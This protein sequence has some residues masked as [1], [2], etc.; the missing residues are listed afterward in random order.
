MLE[1]GVG[2]EVESTRYRAAAGWGRAR[3]RGRGTQAGA[4]D[5]RGERGGFFPTRSLGFTGSVWPRHTPQKNE[6]PFQFLIYLADGVIR[7][8]ISALV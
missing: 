6:A 4:G 5:V 3:C 1:I 8:H 2:A 7:C